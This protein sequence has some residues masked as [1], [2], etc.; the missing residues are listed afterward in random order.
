MQFVGDE[1]TPQIDNINRLTT[2]GPVANIIQ[3]NRQSDNG[4]ATKRR[5]T[6]E[7]FAFDT[8]VDHQTRYI[9][10][11]VDN[12]QFRNSRT[13]SNTNESHDRQLSQHPSNLLNGQQSRNNNFMVTNDRREDA[14]GM[15]FD[16]LENRPTRYPDDQRRSSRN[17]VPVNHWRVSFSGDGQGLHLY[18]FLNQVR[19]LQRSEMIRDHELL[20]MMVHLLTGRAKNWYGNW[21]GTFQTWEELADA[22]QTEFLP[23][24]YRFMLLDKIAMRK[25]KSSETVGEFLALMLSLFRWLEVPISESHKVYIVRNNLLPKYA[26]GVAP[27]NVQS[28]AELAQLCRRI[29]SASQSDNIGLPFDSGSERLNRSGWNRPRMLNV[30]D[31][32]TQQDEPTGD[33]EVCAI[34][35]I[36][37]Q[38]NGAAVKC[39]NCGKTGHI[40]RECC[41]PKDGIFC[42]GCG[43][44]NVTTRTCSSCSGNGRLGAVEEAD[45][46][47][48]QR[49]R[50]QEG[51]MA[52]NREK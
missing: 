32:I 2:D 41:N 24:N 50:G 16:P 29:E 5:P 3:V 51:G 37:R 17:S 45:A 18:E 21:A 48:A 1:W 44:K 9:T 46:P 19:M 47:T 30:V 38:Q 40:F 27:F 34:R 49:T 39:Y 15:Q 7:R 14:A 8:E 23:A 33:E 20:P 4:A 36:Q 25:Q 13:M 28:V 52:I 11:M 22:M 42:Y 31:E 6:N 35:R 10:N 43:S 26:L 12:H